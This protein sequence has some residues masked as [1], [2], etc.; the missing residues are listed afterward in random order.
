MKLSPKTTSMIAAIAALCTINVG[1]AFAAGA[2]NPAATLSHFNDVSQVAVTDEKDNHN[3][4]AVQKDKETGKLV[5]SKNGVVWREFF[6]DQDIETIDFT[7]EGAKMIVAVEKDA[8]N[9]DNQTELCTANITVTS[10]SD[11]NNLT[12]A[13]T[14]SKKDP[15][16]GKMLISQDGGKTWQ[17]TAQAPLK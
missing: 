11:D 2:D 4:F 5:L 1:S 15:Q 3:I 7:V 12:G 8:L 14:M 6:T 10:K 16:T 13:I 9:A 17:E